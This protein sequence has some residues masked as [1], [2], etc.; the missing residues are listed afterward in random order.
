MKAFLTT[1]MMGSFA[2]DQDGKLLEKK[3][4]PKN[5]ELIVEKLDVKDLLPEEEEI[6]RCLIAKGYKEVVCDKEVEFTGIIIVYDKDNPGKKA[7]QESFRGL[8]ISLKWVTSQAELNEIL[9]KVNILRTREKLR[10]ERRDKIII[11]VSGVIEEMDKSINTFCEMIREWYGLYFPELSKDVQSH[12]KFV[13][14]VARFT[15]RRSMKEFEI[16]AK[17]T[18]GM[19]FTDNDLLE[20]K[21]LA[22][23]ILDLMQRKKDL[24]KYLE[25]LCTEIMPNTSAVTGELL[26]AKLL[27]NAGSLEKLS[28][29]PSST[30]QLLGAEKALFRHLKSGGKAPKFGVIFGHAFIQNAAKEK[31]GKVARLIAAKVSLAAKTDFFS[32]EDKG[33]A[34]KKELDEQVKKI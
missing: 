1:N 26:A 27:A 14:L 25:N 6:L 28:R 3:L 32:K 8:A 18:A 31:R 15:K 24:T 20:V 29:L 12:E 16:L 7:L 21:G 23:N 2:F 10:E 33:K 13:D 30:V 4:F 22:M 9:S 34:L 17:K 11:R 19:E 5:P